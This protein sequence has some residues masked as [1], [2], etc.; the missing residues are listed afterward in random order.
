MRIWFDVQ[1]LF[2]Y[3]RW[4]ARPSGIQRLCFEVYAALNALAPDRVRFLRIDPSAARLR[5]VGW[6]EIARLFGDLAAP[7][8]RRAVDRDGEGGAPRPARASAAPRH[9]PGPVPESIPR[10]RRLVRRIPIEIRHPLHAAL[11]HQS[12]A[13]RLLAQAGV[14]GGRLLLAGTR[15]RATAPTQRTAEPAPDIGSELRPGDIIASFGSPWSSPDYPAMIA[16]LREERGMRHALLIYDLIPLLHP[17][18]C[19]R[20]LV[21]CFARF[22][23]GCL[24][25]ADILLTISDA[26]AR[27]IV[28][29]SARQGIRLRAEPR[30]LPPG[31]GFSASSGEA[32]LPC[33][34]A[35]RHVLFVSTIE[36]RKNHAL[37]FRAWRRLLQELPAEQVPPLIFAGRVGWLVDDLMRQ[38]SQSNHLDGKLVVIE[39]P[40]DATIAA[41]Y[42][43]ARFT[44][45]PSLYEGWGLPVSES[46]FFGRVCI[47]SNAASIPEAGGDFCL[48]HDPDSVSDAT[49]LYR[50][51]I[52]SPSL[53]PRLEDRI[54]REWRP[55][56]WSET[57][58]AVLQRLGASGSGVETG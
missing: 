2:D 18:Y 52:L 11:A 56:P 26:T 51:A 49:R 16:R 50:E 38:I 30:I 20:G 42:R 7:P 46:L 8:C 4:N 22:I 28:A 48:Y 27:D 44:I 31:T 12:A 21:A 39:A 34:G 45:F 41:L 47:A 55:R 13:L 14:G 53:I 33:S 54:R 6:P 57:A 36:A 43:E 25:L 29:W 35:G 32:R 58:A 1:D 23:H 3:A 40:D 5:P 19:D 37:A 17:E 10:L 24:P 9:S 15:R